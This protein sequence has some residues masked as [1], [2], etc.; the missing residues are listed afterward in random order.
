MD[1]RLASYTAANVFPYKLFREKKTASIIRS[2][3]VPPAHVQLIPTNRC[4][5]K[6]SFCSCA[7][8]ANADELSFEEI[9]AAMRAMRD[10]GAVAVT[11]TGGGEPLLHPRINDVIAH[12]SWLGLKVGLVSNGAAADLLSGA[13][14]ARLSW[15]RFSC[16]DE[17]PLARVKD[18]VESVARR[19]AGCDLAFSYVVTER[20]DPVNL[21][22]YVQLANDLEFSHVR[23]VSDLTNLEKVVAMDRIREDLARLGANDDRVI[24]QGR[25]E[26]VRGAKRCWISLLKPVVS[27]DGYLFPCCGAQYAE[28]EQALDLRDSMRMGHVREISAPWEAQKPFDGSRCVRCYYAAYNEALEAMLTEIRHMEFI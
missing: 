16:S 14:L 22:R 9:Q 26:Y 19:R 11:I 24:Y 2:G 8:R 12:S 28:E 23:V 20:Y 18:N 25:K 1:S 6:C 15:L 17:L 10:A 4:N 7:N 13:G 27:A 21:S 5:L 3:W